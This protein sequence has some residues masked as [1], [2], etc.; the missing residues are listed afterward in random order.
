M[1]FTTIEEWIGLLIALP[2]CIAS[3]VVQGRAIYRE[4]SNRG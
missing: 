1:F 4:Y 2:I 3:G